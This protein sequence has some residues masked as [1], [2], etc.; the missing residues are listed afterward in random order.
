MPGA[1]GEI[2]LIEDRRL[3]VFAV[4][5]IPV[6]DEAARLEIEHPVFADRGS[7]IEIPFGGEV[8]AQTGIGDFHYEEQFVSAGMPLSVFAAGFRQYRDV[9]FRKAPIAVAGLYFE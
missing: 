6:D 1:R 8:L 5:R 9:R 7:C 3:A 4:G 2:V